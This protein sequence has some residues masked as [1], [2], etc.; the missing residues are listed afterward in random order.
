MVY[1]AVGMLSYELDPKNPL[2]MI[3]K[4][5]EESGQGLAFIVYPAVLSRM[6]SYS[7]VSIKCVKKKKTSE[8]M[9]KD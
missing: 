5:G 8:T 3:D 7:R 4:I 6:G 9:K 1:A 2:A